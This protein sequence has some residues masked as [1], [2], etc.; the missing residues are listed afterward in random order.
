MEAF[1]GREY[2]LY[3]ILQHLPITLEGKTVEVEVEVVDANLIY[4]LL[5]GRSWTYSMRA[6]ASSLFRVIRFPHKEKIVTVDQWSFFASSSSDGNVPFVEHTSNPRES[7]G[8]GLF[9]DPTLMGV[10]SLP[11]PNIAPI[12]TICVRYDPWVLPPAD[13]IESWGDEMSLSPAKLNYVES[14][15]TLAP[16][17]KFSPSSR[18]VNSYVQSPWL[19]DGASSNPLKEIFPSDEVTIE[20]MSF[21]EP[22]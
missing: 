13:Q 2:R 10:F 1:D 15:S 6:V 14:V 4:N 20:T 17:S 22:P 5:L 12:N 18:A 21:E 19:G 3:G 16:S 9:K 11:P 7:V 8:V